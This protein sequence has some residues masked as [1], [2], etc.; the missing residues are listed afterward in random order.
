MRVA[1]HYVPNWIYKLAAAIDAGDMDAAREISIRVSTEEPVEFNQNG[2]FDHAMRL[3]VARAD[4]NLAWL[5]EAEAFL[6]A[7]A[8]N[9]PATPQA[10]EAVMS[11]HHLAGLM[12]LSDPARAAAHF[13]TALVMCPDFLPAQIELEILRSGR[14]RDKIFGALGVEAPRTDWAYKLAASELRLKPRPQP[15]ERPAAAICL[16]GVCT[17]YTPALVRLYRWL[18]PTTPIFVAT[19]NDTPPE[20]LHALQENAQVVLAQDPE[21]P[22]SQNKNRQIVLARTALLAAKNA[23]IS[24]A[25]LLRSDIA[26]FMRDI[27]SYLIS[28]H[29]KFPAAPDVFFGRIIISDVFTR[30]YHAFHLSDMLAFGA[31]P[32][33]IRFWSAEFESGDVY[34]YT[35]QYLGMNLYESIKNKYNDTI[36]NSYYKFLR[37]F[38]IIRDFSWFEGCWLKQPQ[39]RT[40]AHEAFASTCVS[41]TE[42]ERFYHAPASFTQDEMGGGENGLLLNAALGI[43]RP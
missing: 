14:D 35:E 26:L 18:N 8:D 6:A 22:G 30:K 9:W 17:E 16:R 34:T 27:I 7:S 19:W 2:P 41:Q 29:Q 12:R 39:L 4:N 15:I 42:W 43:S 28:T 40:A 36:I 37:D 24:Y 33:L 1:M 38:F 11:A 13:E 21:T 5:E 32:D 25:L 20:I 10:Y 23:D 3:V 31:V